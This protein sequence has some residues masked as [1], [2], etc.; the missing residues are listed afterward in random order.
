MNETLLEESNFGKVLETSSVDWL[1]SV[2]AGETTSKIV[3]GALAVRSILT[4]REHE[5]KANP[6]N[7]S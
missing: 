2:E 5:K 1:V 4:E 7:A 3:D 6:Q